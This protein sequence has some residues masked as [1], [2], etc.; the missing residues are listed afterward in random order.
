MSENVTVKEKGAS[1]NLGKIEL[2]R[3]GKN[4][5]QIYLQSDY[6]FSFLADKSRKTFN[7]GGCEC[8]YPLNGDGSTLNGVNGY[9]MTNGSKFQ[10]EGFLNLSLLLAKDLKSGV[11]FSW[12]C[13]PLTEEQ[14]MD[15]G[16]NFKVQMKLIYCSYIRRISVKMSFSTSII[17]CENLD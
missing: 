12:G 1:L 4:G 9:F 3:D 6:D 8:F 17:E 7:L 2:S 15:Y 13:L 14:L 16:N 10:N 5:F 11:K